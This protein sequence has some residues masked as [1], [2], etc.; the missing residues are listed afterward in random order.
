MP[1]IVHLVRHGEVHNPDHLVYADLPGFGLSSRGR[2]QA[3]AAGTTLEPGP[4]ATVWSSPLLRALRTAE[5]IAAPHRLPVRVHPGLTE[6][7]L[8]VRWHGIA[9]ESVPDAFPGE[10]EAY[11]AD[12]T[13]IPHTPETLAALAERTAAAVEEIRA[14]SATPAVIVGHQDP[15]HAAVRHLTG[16]G[17]DG[18]HVDKPTHAEVITLEGPPWRVVDHAVHEEATR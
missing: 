10:L 8:L 11:L 2:E 3:L 13:E 4:V 1:G 14:G 12:P 16:E 7:G 18:F 6:W 15:I 9:W 5:V 17:L